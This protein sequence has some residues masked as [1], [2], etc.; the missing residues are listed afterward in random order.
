MGAS[1]QRPDQHACCTV[2]QRQRQKIACLATVHE[3]TYSILLPSPNAGRG[4]K[5]QCGQEASNTLP[6]TLSNTPVPS[7]LRRGSPR[8]STKHVCHHAGQ[9]QRMYARPQVSWMLMLGTRQDD[10][11]AACDI[12]ACLPLTASSPRQAPFRLSGV[13]RRHACAAKHPRVRC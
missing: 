1:L 10:R 11:T 7:S 6:G 8:S 2:L 3:L 12:S 9:V 5:R 13:D 4:E